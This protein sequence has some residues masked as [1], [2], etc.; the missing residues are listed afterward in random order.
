MANKS[1]AI[2]AVILIVAMLV[3]MITAPKLVNVCSA[4]A[5]DTIVTLLAPN[6]ATEEGLANHGILE[7]E[8]NTFTPIL[9]HSLVRLEGASFCPSMKGAEG[10]KHIDTSINISNNVSSFDASSVNLTNSALEF[11]VNIDM[12]PNLVTRGLTLVLSDDTGINKIV[13]TI[14]T[15]EIRS[16]FTRDNVSEFDSKIFGSVVNNVPIGWVKLTLPIITG[17]VSG[18]LIKSNRFTFTKLSVTQ[19]AETGSDQQMLF[20]N[21]RL[22]LINNQQTENTSY[23]S[24]YS[25]IK[26]NPSARVLNDGEDYYIGE[27]FPQ[28]MSRR[29]VFLCCWIGNI[30]YLDGAHDGSLKVMTDSGI[31]SSS[32]DYFS[33]GSNNFTIKSSQYTISYG[34]DYG[35]RFV[36][37]LTD[38]MFAANYGKGVWLDSTIKE[39]TIGTECKIYFD[40]HDAFANASIKFSSTDEEILQILEVNTVNN[41]IV[42]K[43][44]KKGDVG[45]KITVTDDRLQGTD[46]EETGIINENF[47]IKVV[48]PA[49]ETNTTQVMLWIAFGLLCVGLLYLAIKAIIDSKKIEVK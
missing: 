6:Y 32:K 18:E 14:T 25:A 44:V 43:A 1:R 30:N 22:V 33:Y 15:D 3:G 41:Y 12:K 8:V 31:G 27:K 10:N 46:Y 39:L 19:T 29:D 5:G 28:L 2:G 36:G 45:I 47:E 4:A 37:L 48:K 20:Y 13:W 21:I 34:L 38:T 24:S 9:E 49:K 23:I 35:G 7:S 16:L 11:W 42:V 17:V 40:V 26:I